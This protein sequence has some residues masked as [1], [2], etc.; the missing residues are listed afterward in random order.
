M[1]QPLRSMGATLHCSCSFA[2]P[3][4][5][6]LQARRS[7]WQN[8]PPAAE[9][10]GCFLQPHASLAASASRALLTGCAASAKDRLAGVVWLLLLHAVVHTWCLTMLPVERVRGHLVYRTHRVW[11]ATTQTHLQKCQKSTALHAVPKRL[12]RLEL[13]ITTILPHGLPRCHSRA[14][15]LVGCVAWHGCLHRPHQHDPQLRMLV[16]LMYT[17]ATY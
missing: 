17:S 10:R 5:P 16:R 3:S 14:V 13:M 8:N 7:P 12:H 11:H 4:A 1:Q 9:T 6:R 15:L 2:S